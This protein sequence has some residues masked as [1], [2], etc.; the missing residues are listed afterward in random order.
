MAALV[1][2]LLAAPVGVRAEDDDTPGPIDSVQDL[3]DSGKIAFKM[4]DVNND[5]RI[6]QKEAVDAGNLMVG[7]FFFRADADGNGVVSKEEAQQARDALLRQKPLLRIILE[8]ATGQRSGQSGQPAQAGQG[9]AQ[10]QDAMQGVMSI[11]DANND[12]Q[13]QATELRQTVQTG[14]QG[15]Y[16]GADTDR[17]GHLTPTELNSAVSGMVQAAAQASFQA[18]DKDSNGQ[19]SQAEFDQMIVEPARVVFRVIDANGDGQISQQESQNA[20]RTVARQ[21]RMLNVPEPAN[22]LSNQIEN[23]SQPGGAPVIGSPSTPNRTTPNA[24]RQPRRPAAPA[25]PAQPQ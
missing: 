15:L 17:D 13:L 4:A 11:V 2:G 8:R 25:A 22:S 18:A 24:P 1:A 14:V 23:A 12:G 21:I 10:A 5:N 7:G 3:Q 6:S 19:L 9:N 20:Q 16:A